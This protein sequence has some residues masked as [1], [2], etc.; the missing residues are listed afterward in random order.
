MVKKNPPVANP[1]SEEP[2]VYIVGLPTG[3]HETP[4]ARSKFEKTVES[5]RKL[6]PIT[7]ARAT[8]KV[9]SP[10]GERRRFEVQA[11]IRM[12]RDQFEFSHEGWSLA[13]TFDGLVL[14]LKRLRTKPKSKPSYRRYPSRAERESE[15][16]R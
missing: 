5:L 7:E 14:K 4:L 8:V 1:S 6:Y 2:R 13:E 12:P 15:L 11:L 3:D 10:L 16:E 9:S